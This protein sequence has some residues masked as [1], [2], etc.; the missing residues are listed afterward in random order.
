MG[1]RI[2]SRLREK[3]ACL[4][5]SIRAFSLL[6]AERRLERGEDAVVISY[7]SR[8]QY[9][10]KHEAR[11]ITS[12]I[13]AIRAGQKPDFHASSTRN[14]LDHPALMIQALAIRSSFL[15]IPD[16][17]ASERPKQGTQARRDEMR[18]EYQRTMAEAVKGKLETGKN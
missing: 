15:P 9:I 14:T 12:W 2:D 1:V 18:A 8:C 6:L 13:D 16:E 11:W 10:W 17:V 3:I 5:R 4:A 7:F